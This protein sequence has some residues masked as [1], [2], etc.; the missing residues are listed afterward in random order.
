MARGLIPVRR[1]V[2]LRSRPGPR[3]DMRNSDLGGAARTC[4]GPDAGEREVAWAAG[5]AVGPDRTET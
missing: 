2:Y 1:D 5:T 4:Y 3:R